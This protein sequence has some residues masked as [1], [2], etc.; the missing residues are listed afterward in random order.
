MLRGIIRGRARLGWEPPKTITLYRGDVYAIDRFK[1]FWTG[2]VLMVIIEPGS[3]Y[4]N[5]VTIPITVREG[6]LIYIKPWERLYKV[7]KMDRN[8]IVLELTG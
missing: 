3:V 2:Y 6:D 8:H 5:W 4:Q 7:T 1:Y